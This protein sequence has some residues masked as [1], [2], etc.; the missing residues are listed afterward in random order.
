MPIISNNVTNIQIVNTPNKILTTGSKMSATLGDDAL[1]YLI[2]IAV[3]QVRQI[4]I[5]LEDN[6]EHG[7]YI[8]P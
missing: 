2:K 8:M 4:P 3:L 7:L 6:A 5:H 1:V